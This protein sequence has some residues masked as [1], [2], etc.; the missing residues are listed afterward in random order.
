LQAAQSGPGRIL[1][2]VETESGHGGGSTLEQHV[3]QDTD[4]LAFLS[5]NLGLPL[6]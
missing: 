1:L 2:R 4:I 3:E 6:E 5:R